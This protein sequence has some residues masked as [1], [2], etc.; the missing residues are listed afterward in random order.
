MDNLAAMMDNSEVFHPLKSSR[1]GGISPLC[2]SQE[3]L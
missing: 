3:D 2:Q 1:T